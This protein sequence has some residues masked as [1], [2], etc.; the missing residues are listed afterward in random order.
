MDE[1]GQD[2]LVVGDGIHTLDNPY[3]GE[4]GCWC[5]TSVGYHDL[6][7]HPGVTDEDVELAYGFYEL[8]R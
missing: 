3:C 2:V 1:Q 5:H 6:V 4:T 7:T 8:A